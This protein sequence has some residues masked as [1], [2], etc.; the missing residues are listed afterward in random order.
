MAISTTD[1]LMTRGVTLG[2]SESLKYCTPRSASCM[3][4][5]GTP[6]VWLAAKRVTI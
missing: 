5:A 3:S 2:A 6:L 1:T 4:E